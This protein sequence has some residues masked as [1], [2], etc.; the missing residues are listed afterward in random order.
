MKISVTVFVAV[1]SDPNCVMCR[2]RQSVGCHG[3][4]GRSDADD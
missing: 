2:G 1:V 4:S 3:G